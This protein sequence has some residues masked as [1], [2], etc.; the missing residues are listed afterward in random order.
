MTEVRFQ[1]SSQGLADETRV[2][3]ARA[4]LDLY[5]ARKFERALN[6]AVS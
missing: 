1:A 4:E 3:T 6:G 5:T 2:V